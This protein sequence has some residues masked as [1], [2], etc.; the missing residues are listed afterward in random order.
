MKERFSLSNTQFSKAIEA[1]NLTS[2]QELARVRREFRDKQSQEQQ[3]AA[4]KR[5]ETENF[6]LDQV[7]QAEATSF[8]WR[9]Q[10]ARGN[11]SRLASIQKERVEAELA[12]AQQKIQ[13]EMAAEQQKAIGV[14]RET[15]NG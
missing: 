10:E 14:L 5:L 8:D 11:A 3:A 9:E 1:I 12:L 6:I 2:E 13:V 15:V 7:R 4:Q